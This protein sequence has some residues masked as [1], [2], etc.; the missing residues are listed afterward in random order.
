MV[1]RAASGTNHSNSLVGCL[2]FTNHPNSVVVCLLL[3]NHLNSVVVCLL[4]HKPFKQCGCVPLVPL[5][6]PVGLPRIPQE[7]LRMS[8]SPQGAHVSR[9]ALHKRITKVP[10]D[11]NNENKGQIVAQYFKITIFRNLMSLNTA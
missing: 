3:T 1:E 8:V 4:L 9:S 2:L 6:N 10:Y 5:L 7:E 11:T